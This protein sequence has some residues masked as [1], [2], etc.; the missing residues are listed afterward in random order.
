MAK[1]TVS[2]LLETT[3]LLTTD[4]GEQLK[5]LVNYTSEMAENIA[6]LLRNGLSFSDNFNCQIREV[7]VKHEV[8]EPVG[9]DKPVLGIIPIRVLSTT[10]DLESF[11]WHYDERG[12]LVVRA[13]F[14]GAPANSQKL[15]LVLLF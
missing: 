8:L 2:R 3:R 1:Y 4:A 14:T 15:T 5:D 13:A 7:S 9:A 10:V 11:G 12:R 6:R